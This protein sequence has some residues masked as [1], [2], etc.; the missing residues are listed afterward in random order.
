MRKPSAADLESTPETVFDPPMPPELPPPVE[1]CPPP[2]RN[3]PRQPRHAAS[4]TEA[5]RAV[6]RRQLFCY[7][8]LIARH[9]E[10]SSEIQDL[11]DALAYFDDG[12]NLLPRSFGPAVP[13][14]H[15]RTGRNDDN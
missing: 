11:S 7:E 5:A 15:R 8:H 10:L 9:P 12:D 4:A 14:S 1:P 6:V 13:A 2:N 3:L